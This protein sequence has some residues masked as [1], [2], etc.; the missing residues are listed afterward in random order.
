VGSEERTEI[1]ARHRQSPGVVMIG[2][3]PEAI[4]PRP[5]RS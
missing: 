1:Q 4:V 2:N 3:R 5:R